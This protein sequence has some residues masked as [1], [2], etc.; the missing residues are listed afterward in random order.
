M[1]GALQS[2]RCCIDCCWSRY[3]PWF[4]GDQWWQ[5]CWHCRGA[6][7]YVKQVG[8]PIATF[9]R[10]RPGPRSCFA[11]GGDL[12]LCGGDLNLCREIRT[13]R[14]DLLLDL[15]QSVTAGCTRTHEGQKFLQNVSK[16][17]KIEKLRLHVRGLRGRIFGI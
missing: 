15:I 7:W 17:L 6:A 16:N 9:D 8:I 1:C 10:C 5:G 4:V 2:D 12:Y 11:C 13:L 3:S 14:V